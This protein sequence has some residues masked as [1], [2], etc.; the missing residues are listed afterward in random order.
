VCLR[1]SLVI[2]CAVERWSIVVVDVAT[3]ERQLAYRGPEFVDV[4]SIAPDD[5]RV[6]FAVEGAIYVKTLP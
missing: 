1:E 2:G 3:G 5:D 6:A 4:P